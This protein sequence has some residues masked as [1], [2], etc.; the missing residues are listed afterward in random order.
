MSIDLRAGFK[1][2][3]RKCLHE[4]IDM[5]PPPAKRVYLERGSRGAWEIGSF[6][7]SAS[8]GYCGA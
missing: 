5:V 3:H 1:E 2:R 8:T 7:V 4:A 6:D